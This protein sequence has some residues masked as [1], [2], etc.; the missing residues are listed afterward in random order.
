VILQAVNSAGRG[1]LST[2]PY[3]SAFTDTSLLRYMS[4]QTISTGTTL[5]ING[6]G[7]RAF[8][9][10]TPSTH[11][12]DVVVDVVGYFIKPM[13]ATADKTGKLLLGSRVVS[14]SGTTGAYDVRFDRG[15]VGCNYQ[16]TAF[17][18][19]TALV[20]SAALVT[21]TT[22]TILVRTTV[23]GTATPGRST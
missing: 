22:T 16:A 11:S 21:G 2:T 3:G 5:P 4:G 17:T 23:N 15:V 6:N 13:T 20:V 10:Q 14:V 19:S 1:Y 7:A 8:S 18:V 12:T 9:L